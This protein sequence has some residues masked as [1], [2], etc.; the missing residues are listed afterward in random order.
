MK[1]HSGYGLK[2]PMHREVPIQVETGSSK[3]ASVNVLNLSMHAKTTA[4][5]G[6]S[7]RATHPGEGGGGLERLVASNFQTARKKTKK[8]YPK[9]T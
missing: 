2:P 7:M 1:L 9:Q 4:I 3:Q 6:G 5:S 8:K